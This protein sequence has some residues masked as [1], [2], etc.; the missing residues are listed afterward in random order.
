MKNNA[1]NFIL[2]LNILASHPQ[3]VHMIVYT[4]I[5]MAVSAKVTAEK[6]LVVSTE[7]A[8]QCHKRFLKITRYL[9][10]LL[11]FDRHFD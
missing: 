2:K 4:Q 1:H 6:M 11:Q 9:T 3:R 8:R 5:V 10:H 7:R